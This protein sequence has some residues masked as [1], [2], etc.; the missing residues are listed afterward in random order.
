MEVGVFPR[1]AGCIDDWR[2]EGVGEAGGKNAEVGMLVP[3]CAWG[4]DDSQV[5]WDE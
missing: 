5:W 4:K 3:N 2:I 1:C